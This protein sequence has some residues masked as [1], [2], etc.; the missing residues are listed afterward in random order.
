MEFSRQEYRSGL[1]CPP[2]GD[3]HSAGTEP[4]A[5]ALH[6]DSL[7]SGPPRKYDVTNHFIFLDLMA[8]GRFKLMA[9]LL[10]ALETEWL[11][12]N[13]ASIDVNDQNPDISSAW[14]SNRPIIT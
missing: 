11:H 12:D 1:P 9:V 7:P 14:F 8:G 2:P 3:L 10:Q 13:E 4:K 5:P 6:A